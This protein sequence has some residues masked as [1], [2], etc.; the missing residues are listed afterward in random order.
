MV[1]TMTIQTSTTLPEYSP[2]LHA[3]IHETTARKETQFRNWSSRKEQI[4]EIFGKSG[5]VAIS[6]LP[7]ITVPWFDPYFL[8]LG[9]SS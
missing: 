1:H 3:D 8:K 6:F 4:T 5:Y 2:L 9:H 7:E